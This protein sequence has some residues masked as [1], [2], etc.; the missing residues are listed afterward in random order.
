[1]LNVV[2]AWALGLTGEGVVVTILDDGIEKTHP[3]LAANYDPQASYDL[4]DN[5]MNPQPRYTE[6]NENRH[7]TRCAGE[8]AAVANN[9]V[10]GVGVAYRAQIGG[11]G[12]GGLGSIYVWASG[13]GG[14]HFDNCNCDGYA[15][16]MYTVSVGSTT[17]NG[18]V[19]LYSEPCPAI[20]TTTYSS[21]GRHQRKIVT[22][23]LR[24]TCTMQH[25]GTSASAPLAAGIIALALEANPTL[26]WR[27]VQHIVIRASRAA[28]LN[29]DDWRPNGVGRRV[30][31]HY[32]YGLLDAGKL[33][34]LARKWSTVQ[35]QRMC[36]VDIVTSPLVLRGQLLLKWNVTACA[37]SGQWVR[38]LE[39][40]QARLSLKYSR[41]GDLEISLTSPRGTR[42]TL[43][44]ARQDMSTQGYSDWAFMT[45]H[46]WDEDPR[47]VWTM[48]FDDKGDSANT[49]MLSH[50]HLELYGTEE[51][52]A[53]RRVERT[54]VEECLG[55][56]PKGG[57]QECR[58]PLF[59]FGRICLLSCPPHYYE[60][61]PNGTAGRRC[62][63]CHPSCQLCEGAGQRSCRGCPPFSTFDP[64]LS[65][66]S[67]PVYPWD[68]EHR[69]EEADDA[70][71]GYNMLVWIVVFFLISII[72]FV[73][74]SDVYNSEDPWPRHSW[75]DSE[76]DTEMDNEMDTEMD[77]LSVS[78]STVSSEVDEIAEATK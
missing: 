61:G 39:H 31:H 40:V 66:C 4:N 58:F 62:L 54:V 27:D 43:V 44:S 33:V 14:T 1:D 10:C 64:K 17:E 7:G 28:G 13:N 16:S 77:D 48:Q 24:G 71:W 8:V 50:F 56:S 73:L 74:A 67:P 20:L 59:V 68:R 49:G 38:G 47:G 46:C 53:G 5:D 65:T 75:R 2:S 11:K 78:C 52:V 32:G 3:D 45:T 26:T 25:S 12:R 29:A 57:C 51:N 69:D 22:T 41:R 21:G 36:R 37:G 34:D 60:W 23:D 19:P 30:S 6:A 72:A 15:N 55:W 42:S 76:M 35:P 18:T 70:G 63:P 9:A